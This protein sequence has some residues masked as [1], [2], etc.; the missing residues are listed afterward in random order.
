MG[1][2][3]NNAYINVKL[4]ETK[5]RDEATNKALDN[6]T[7]SKKHADTVQKMSK[8]VA[9]DKATMS[10]VKTTYIESIKQLEKVRDSAI[11]EAMAVFNNMGPN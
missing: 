5:A 10:L 7:E 11:S 4:Y 1:T 9:V 6:F 2:R 8:R 3:V